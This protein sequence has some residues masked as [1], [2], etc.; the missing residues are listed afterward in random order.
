M[1]RRTFLSA[2]VLLCFLALPAFSQ[3]QSGVASNIRDLVTS[4]GVSTISVIIAGA[5]FATADAGGFGVPVRA[6]ALKTFKLVGDT[7][8]EL[9]SGKV[10][11]TIDFASALGFAFDSS[12]KEL[13]IFLR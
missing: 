13:D 11:F 8:L 6:V 3:S 7:V 1:G 4:G 10:Q 5:V 9:Q 2:T 12:N